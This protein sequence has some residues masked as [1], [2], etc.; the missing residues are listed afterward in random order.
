MTGAGPERP[1]LH[2]LN[3]EPFEATLYHGSGARFGEFDRATQVTDQTLFSCTEENNALL[4]SDD[5][6]RGSML[7]G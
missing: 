6:V 2:P 4:T 3:A 5:R 1:E 7:R